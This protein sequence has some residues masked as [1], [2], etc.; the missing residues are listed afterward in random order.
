MDLPRNQWPTGFGGSSESPNGG[1]PPLRFSPPCHLPSQGS[2][3]VLCNIHLRAFLLLKTITFLFMEVVKLAGL[4]I[5]FFPEVCWREL[6]W[7]IQRGLR[8]TECALQG[9]FERC[10]Q[11][12]K[13]CLKSFQAPANKSHSAKSQTPIFNQ[14]ASFHRKVGR[15][16][17]VCTSPIWLYLVRAACRGTGIVTTSET[18]TPII[19]ACNLYIWHDCCTHN[20]N[21]ECPQGY[22]GFSTTVTSIQGV[23]MKT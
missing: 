20:H 3:L 18:I 17:N 13:H 16:N 11:C 2:V 14:A 7:I 10:A 6:W 23:E 15:E 21:K 12:Q 4:I 8:Y 19:L 5:F 9:V 1:M 22:H